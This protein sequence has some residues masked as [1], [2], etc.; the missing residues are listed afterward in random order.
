MK[1]IYSIFISLF[2][3][4]CST[5]DIDYTLARM[6]GNKP[7]QFFYFATP[8]DANQYM[9]HHKDFD[10]LMPQTKEIDWIDMGGWNGAYIYGGI[11]VGL[12]IKEVTK[13][14]GVL[15]YGINMNSSIYPYTDREREIENKI[16]NFSPQRTRPDGETINVNLH[17]ET[18]GKEDYT[19]IVNSSYNLNRGVY[20]KY[21]GCYKF[22][23]EKTKA[24]K[25][26]ITFI[27]T[28]S[29]NLPQAY[30]HLAKEYTYEDLLKRSQ[31]VL[32]SLYI[33]DDWKK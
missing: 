20:E 24:K 21:Y 8:S 33:K 13:Y 11:G 27:Y 31:R 32:D 10:M 2:F 5:N 17:Y 1:Y 15:S 18:H 19:C 30:Q 26:G 12:D 3:L 6:A 22:N 14:G 16:K 25:V 4:G 29:P 28:K 7:A 9:F 23:Q